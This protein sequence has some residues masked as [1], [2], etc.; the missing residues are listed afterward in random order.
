MHIP[1]RL[2]VS[3]ILIGLTLLSES[4]I[5][6]TYT[7]DTSMLGESGADADV[8]LFNE[9]NQLPG[10]YIVDIVLNG[11]LVDTRDV[12]FSV[13]QENDRR[14]LYPCLGVSDLA[15]YGVRTE[16][17]PNLDD[18]SGAHY[19]LLCQEQRII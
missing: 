16:D 17:F 11:E 8:S 19:S 15:R 14:V 2:S 13:L 12:T 6:R 3:A 9:G 7:F 4:S 10:N 5:A 18:G 1:S